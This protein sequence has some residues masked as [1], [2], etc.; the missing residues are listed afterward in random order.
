MKEGE[1]KI[2]EAEL[3]VRRSLQRLDVPEWMKTATP[4]QG[5]ILRRKEGTSSSTGG[6][7]AFSS[8]TGSM[9]SLG[10]SRANTP[11]KVIIPTRASTRSYGGIT[12]PASTASISPSPSDRVDRGG[13]FQYP[14]SRWS[15]SRI[16]SGTTTPTGSL[17]SQKT[18]PFTRQQPYLG[19]R[20]NT[21][22]TSLGGSQSSLSG[23]AYLSPAERL[24]LTLCQTKQNEPVVIQ[25]D[26]STVAPSSQFE[27][28]TTVHEISNDNDTTNVISPK[29]Y[30]DR[31]QVADV[32]SS[33]K[34]VTSAIVHYCKE[35]ESPRSSPRSSPNAFNRESSPRRR[36]WVESSFVGSRPITSPETP[37]NTSSTNVPPLSP[38]PVNGH[39]EELVENRPTQHSGEYLMAW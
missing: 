20:S 2:S 18:A 23:N 38:P 31:S 17:S 24:A 4:Q 37:T 13:L 11:T 12:S 29:I 9:T 27:A 6:W 33:I 14:L 19:W 8:K 34:E 28:N 21:S 36:V 7:S 1:R 22:L 3:R 30:S 35:T 25:K 26:S 15:T 32:H 10:S 39:T 5:F 16:N